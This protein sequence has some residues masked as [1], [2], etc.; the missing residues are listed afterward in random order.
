L[1]CDQSGAINLGLGGNHSL[2]TNI[3]TLSVGQWYHVALTWN[4]TNY[5]VYVDGTLK[6]TGTYSGLSS[7]ASYA[8]I[9]NDG[10]DLGRFEAFNGLIDEVRIYD[11]AIGAEEI[12]K[13]AGSR[14]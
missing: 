14:Q 5:A 8:D 10:A 9:G 6:S 13:L 3:Q 12:V 11:V 1:Y 7:L 4:G 2:K